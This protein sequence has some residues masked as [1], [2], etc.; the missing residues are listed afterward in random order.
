[1]QPRMRRAVARY[2]TAPV[3]G[4]GVRS[5]HGMVFAA[6]PASWL[7]I[8]ARGVVKRL[9]G[10]LASRLQRLHRQR[11][12][13]QADAVLG[14]PITPEQLDWC[15]RELLKLRPE[16]VVVDTVFRA[17]VFEESGCAGA[18]RLLIATDLFHLRHRAL[19]EAGYR[20]YP[21]ELTEQDEAVLL[22][23]ADVIAALQPEEAAV[24]RTLCPQKRVPGL[25]MPALP[26]PRPSGIQRISGRLVF[27]GSDSLP[28]LDGLRWWFAEIWPLLKTLY[29]AVT[30]DLVGDCGAAFAPLPGNV[31][32][33]GRVED[34]A[35]PLH[36]AALAIAPLRV[37]SG[38]KIKTLDYARHGLVTVG[39]GEALR[40]LA[41]DPA[42]PFILAE[43]AVGF[44]QA[45]AEKLRHPDLEDEQRALRYVAARYGRAASFASLAASLG[46]GF[47]SIKA[48]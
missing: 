45:V 28:N 3:T 1:V 13:A 46:L 43:D 18:L 2:G 35:S 9:P 36:R 17:K 10:A 31:R 12:Y 26:C 5:W 44:A 19:R 23:L 37:G 30:L 29:P 39:T 32:W 24:I 15:N 20:V 48:E 27:V 22:N 8:L 25:P 21:A 40:G 34:L 16:I 14:A 42:R 6:S 7:A 11:H 4:I 41:P 47:A 38:L 33:L